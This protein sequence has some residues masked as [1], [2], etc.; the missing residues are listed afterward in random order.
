MKKLNKVAMLFAAAEHATDTGAQTLTT[1]KT[2]LAI[3][4]GR[5]APTN[6]AGVTASGHLQPLLLVAMVLWLH[7]LLLQQLWLSCLSHLSCLRLHSPH[8]PLLAR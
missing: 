4:S 2:A 3:S 5:T 7:L 1:G 8:L 6:C